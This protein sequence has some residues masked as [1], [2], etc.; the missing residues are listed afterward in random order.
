M[1]D[2]M[3]VRPE[4]AADFAA[5]RQVNRLAFGQEGEAKLVDALR[6]GG[7]ARLSL[8]AE[9]NDRVVGHI[10]FSDL[11]IIT[12]ERT[13][14]ALALAP[15]AVLPEHQGCGIGSALVRYGLD[16]CRQHG[17][18]IVVVLGHPQF[19]RRCGFSPEL[20]LALQS[21]FSGAAWM[22]LELVP[23]ALTGI[24]GRVQY[25]PPFLAL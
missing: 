20:A 7:Y 17:H 2:C 3:F 6:D 14:S 5:I 21:P 9:R 15:L 25:S 10:L 8:I 16:E 24:R 22:A 18:K 12:G 1:G 13:V 19:Y 23:G 4:T 11:P